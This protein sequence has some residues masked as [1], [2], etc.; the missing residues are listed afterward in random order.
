MFRLF[1]LTVLTMLLVLLAVLLPVMASAQAQTD[2]LDNVMT[3]K[4]VQRFLE[5]TKYEAANWLMS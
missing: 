5:Y 1:R 3:E 4:M 2:L